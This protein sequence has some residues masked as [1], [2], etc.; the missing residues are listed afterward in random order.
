MNVTGKLQNWEIKGNEGYCCPSYKEKDN[1]YLT[2]QKF[3][4]IDFMPCYYIFFIKVRIIPHGFAT[5]AESYL[6]DLP[7]R[8]NHTSRI[9]HSGRIKPR[10]FATAAAR[11]RSPSND[12]VFVEEKMCLGQDIPVH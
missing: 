6:A 1:L 3:D 7:Q 4:D 11:V 9:C 2:L 5:A 8:Q 12:V 10:G